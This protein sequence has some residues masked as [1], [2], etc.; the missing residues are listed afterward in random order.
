MRES[1]DASRTYV[2]ELP[3]VPSLAQ[4]A[5]SSSS[6][7][8]SGFSSGCSNESST[9][10]TVKHSISSFA[11]IISVGPEC[12]PVL[13]AASAS[14]EA[15]QQALEKRLEEDSWRMKTTARARQRRSTCGQQTRRRLVAAITTWSTSIK[16]KSNLIAR[17][18]PE[19]LLALLTLESRRIACSLVEYNQFLMQ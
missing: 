14:V 16:K 8:S 15:I 3:R 6:D 1:F 12:T 19:L 2:A 4:S 7:N 18:L 5:D 9:C 13:T 11:T 10:F 17:F